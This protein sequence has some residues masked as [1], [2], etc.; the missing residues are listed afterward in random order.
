MKAPFATVSA[1]LVLAGLMA[2]T[3]MAQTQVVRF[4]HNE[5]DPPSIEFFNNAIAE[6][7][8][9]HPDID[10]QM[11]AISTDGRLQKVMASIN[12]RSMPE[13][14]K[15]LP[16][17]RFDFAERGYL[18]P[19]DDTLEEIGGKDAYLEG[20]LVEVDGHVYDIPY[21]LGNFGL[22]FYR[23][24]LFEE[25]GLEPAEDWDAVK[26]NAETLTDS[27]TYGFIFPA[28]KNRMASIFLS[29]MIWSAGGRI[30]TRIS[31]SPST[32]RAPLRR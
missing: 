24:D 26:A 21:T 30:S 3:A 10:V 18:V 22:Y 13:V 4:L 7:E 16:E 2:S 5:T 12:T 32:I 15:L 25:A 14:F 27:D 31:T 11:E 29:E 23:S 28:G 6:F 17:E 19:L 8:E 1:G 9:Q 20:S